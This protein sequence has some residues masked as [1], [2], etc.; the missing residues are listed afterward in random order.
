MAGRGRNPTDVIEVQAGREINHLFGGAITAMNQD[1][2][3]LRL[4]L[5]PARFHD[6]GRPKSGMTFCQFFEASPPTKVASTRRDRG[7][8]CSTFTGPLDSGTVMGSSIA[9]ISSRR[10]S[11][12]GGNSMCVPSSV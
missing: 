7:T 8:A 12:H 11:N 9:I 3:Q 4:A 2:T 6:A 5:R 10:L 1:A